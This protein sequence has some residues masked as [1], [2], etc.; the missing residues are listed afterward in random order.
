MMTKER[1][2]INPINVWPM[3]EAINLPPDLLRSYAAGLGPK[4][5]CLRLASLLSEESIA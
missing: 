5:L 2:I 4:G 3:R 1:I